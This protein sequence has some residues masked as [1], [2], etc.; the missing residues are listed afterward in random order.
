VFD[1]A[2][3]D[4]PDTSLRRELEQLFRDNY[5]MLYRTAYSILHNRED[6][7]D[8]PQTIF[9]R[10][11]RTGVSPDVGKNTTGYLYRAVVNQSLSILRSRKRHITGSAE[12]LDALV[13]PDEVNRAEK[14]H[15]CLSEAMRDLAPEAVHLLL[16]RYVH[17]YRDAE[18]AKLLGTSRVAVAVRLYRSRARLKK[19][20]QEFLEKANE[21]SST[22][23]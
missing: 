6:A 23:F 4:V 15:R 10:L 3:S 19:L 1:V 5:Q 20:M 2:V 18:I 17:N 21:T 22:E 12:L 9:L 11:L 13:H 14:R 7:E 16:L 8:V